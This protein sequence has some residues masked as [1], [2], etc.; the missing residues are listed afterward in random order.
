MSPTTMICRIPSTNPKMAKT[1][2][3]SGPRI[4]P[5][6]KKR[7]QSIPSA[8]Y[9]QEYP[10]SPSLTFKKSIAAGICDTTQP[11]SRRRWMGARE[12]GGAGQVT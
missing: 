5:R 6:T 2:P 10:L 7:A 12:R 8:G 3:S 1:F 9:H 4:P 11:G